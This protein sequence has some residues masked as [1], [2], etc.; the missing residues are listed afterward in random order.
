ML[1]LLGTTTQKFLTKQ[2]QWRSFNNACLS[3]WLADDKSEG[4][5][6]R[7][8]QQQQQ[9]RD[10]A[11]G[12]TGLGNGTAGGLMGSFGVGG[13]EGWSACGEMVC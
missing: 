10:A 1:G 3:V 5:P 6:G 11:G 9:Q 2:Q 12:T 13:R 7:C 8:Q 4:R